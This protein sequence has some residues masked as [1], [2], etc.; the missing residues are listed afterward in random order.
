MGGAHGLT[1]R[2][3]GAAPRK[4]PAVVPLPASAAARPRRAYPRTFS[5][6]SSSRYA[7]LDPSALTMTVIRSLCNPAAPETEIRLTDVDDVRPG[8]GEVNGHAARPWIW[9]SYSPRLTQTAAWSGLRSG[10]FAAYKQ[11]FLGRYSAGA[12][13]SPRARSAG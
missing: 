4:V 11:D 3:K 9:A 6:T 2:R 5:S 7:T 13:A 12:S 1:A 10:D 8:P